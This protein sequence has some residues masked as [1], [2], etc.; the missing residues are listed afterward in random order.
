[1]RVK[2]MTTRYTLECECGAKVERC[3]MREK[4]VCYDCKVKLK[5]KWLKKQK[6]R[7]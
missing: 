3:I 4:V 7:K 5:E 1:M 6:K 2:G